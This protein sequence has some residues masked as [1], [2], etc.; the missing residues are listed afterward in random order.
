MA[1]VVKTVFWA[2][3]ELAASVASAW[4]ALVALVEHS[5]PTWL[6]LTVQTAFIVT[7]TVILFMLAVCVAWALLWKLVLSKIRFV[8]ALKNELLLGEPS[9]PTQSR[10]RTPTRARPHAG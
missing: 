1:D 9:H 5:L 3:R 10:R 2:T 8:V 6:F 7:T 4:S